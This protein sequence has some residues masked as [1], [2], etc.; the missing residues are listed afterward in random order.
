MKN[1]FNVQLGRQLSN[2]KGFSGLIL[3]KLMNKNNYPMYLDAYHLLEFEKGDEVLEIGF[4]NG[5]FIKEIVDLTEPGKYSGI[6]ISDTMIRTAKKRN[7]SLINNGKVKLVKAHARLLPFEDESFDKVFTIN[8]IYF[9]EHPNQVMQEI[10]RVLKPGG[11]FVVALGTK[12]AMEKNGYF[13]ERFMLYTKEDVEKLFIDGG[14]TDLKITY[15][16]LK[17][18][19]VLCIRGVLKAN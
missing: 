15:G 19:D 6:D 8:T 5:A 13:E 10:K 1:W 3:G 11:V 18:E 9:W 7:R 4:G 17:I 14:F 12:E 2:P 16:K